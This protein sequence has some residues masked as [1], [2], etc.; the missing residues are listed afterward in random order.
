MNQ[1][2]HCNNNI[3]SLSSNK[4]KYDG[5]ETE[6]T[7]CLPKPGGRG[8]PGMFVVESAAHFTMRMMCYYHRAL[9]VLRSSRWLDGETRIATKNNATVQT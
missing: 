3:K 8:C 6:E 1:R 9:A 4:N 5:N 7:A 2:H